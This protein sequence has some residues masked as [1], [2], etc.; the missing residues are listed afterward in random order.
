MKTK[1]Y[2]NQHLGLGDHIVTASLVRH[3]C[4]IYD[5]VVLFCLPNIE[6]TLQSLFKDL[7]NLE[8]LPIEVT[9]WVGDN[10]NIK[11]YIQDN[12]LE[13][14]EIK[15]TNINDRT[16]PFDMGFYTTQGFDPSFRFT[17]FYYERDLVSEEHVF[18]TVNPN[19]EKYIFVID[20]GKHYTGTN[21]VIGDENLPTE[22]KIIRHDKTLS[23][24]DDRFVLFNYYKVL[25]NAEEIHM[26]ES[27]F[28]HFICSI[29]KLQKPKIYIYRS[30][31]GGMSSLSSKENEFII[32]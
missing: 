31:R 32:L 21:F 8:I 2:I 30:M 7:K 16:V 1:K 17:N 4:S 13:N 12:K 27:A 14:D 5:E 28:T 10:D 26:I 19:N 18:N 15:I 9:L 23:F 3:F 25:E 24:T 20:D 22:Y 29:D 6:T 11:K